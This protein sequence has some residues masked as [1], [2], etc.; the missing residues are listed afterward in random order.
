MKKYFLAINSIVFI[1]SLLAGIFII[2]TVIKPGEL[3]NSN[4]V[5]P[6]VELIVRGEIL[7]NTQD[8]F[9]FK[10]K[11]TEGQFG[12]V[13]IKINSDTDFFTSKLLKENGVTYGREMTKATQDDLSSHKSVVVHWGYI[14]GVGYVATNV[15]FVNSD[16]NS[17]LY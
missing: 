6:Y 16:T 15:T 3:G 9:T 10:Y 17:I 11:K 7:N 14:D 5:G 8:S 4:Q 1:A 12:Y 2:N 13:E